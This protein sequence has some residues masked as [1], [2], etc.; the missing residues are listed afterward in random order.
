VLVSIRP[1]DVELGP[2]EAA[3]GEN[4]LEGTV[5]SAVYMGSHVDYQVAVEGVRIRAYSKPST[6]YREGDR[7]SLGLPPAACV[8][9][10]EEPGT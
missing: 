4:R 1:E 7:V 5:A 10:P 8:C 2:A 6:P 3:G 9:I